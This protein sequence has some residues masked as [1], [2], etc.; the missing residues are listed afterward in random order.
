MEIM[1][2]DL[3][4]DAQK[5]LLLEAGV[6]RPEDM[7]WDEDPVAVVEFD[8][9]DFELDDDPYVDDDVDEMDDMDDAYGDEN[10]YYD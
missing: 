8:N 2:D 7:D 9:D 10:D 4:E 1:F 6:S 3:T 5:R